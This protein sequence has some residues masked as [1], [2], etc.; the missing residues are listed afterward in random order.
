MILTQLDLS[1]H[2]HMKYIFIYHY[3]FIFALNYRNFIGLVYRKMGIV[4]KMKTC[5]K[6][7]QI[8]KKLKEEETNI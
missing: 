6:K 3:D 1:K 2:L 5:V 8:K 7:I 4:P